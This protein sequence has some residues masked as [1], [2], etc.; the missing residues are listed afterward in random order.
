MGNKIY[1][2]LSQNYTFLARLISFVTGNKYSHVSLSFNKECTDMRSIGRVFHWWPLSGKYTKE[3][4]NKG[5][6]I[7]NKKSK[8][9]V[10]ELSISKRKY[11]NIVN[12]LDEY[13]SSCKGYNTIGLICA[14]FNKKINR[15][16]YYCTEFIY[17]ILSDDKVQLFPKTKNVVKPMD[18]TKIKRL[19]KI[20]EGNTNDYNVNYNIICEKLEV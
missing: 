9:L 15:N 10:C 6:F 18:F 16:K 11:N 7:S 5:V 14:A 2:V 3:S 13:G 4:I 17:K 19:K 12:L 1:I 8:I 20:Y